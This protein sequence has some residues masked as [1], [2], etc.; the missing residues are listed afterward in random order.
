[1]QLGIRFLNE[2]YADF[3]TVWFGFN[4]QFPILTRVSN[5]ELK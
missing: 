5:V 1:M 2:F 3:K 4:H